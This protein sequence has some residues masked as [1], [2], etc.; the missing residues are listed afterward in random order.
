MAIDEDVDHDSLTG[1]KSGVS[2]DRLP[3]PVGQAGFEASLEKLR[4]LLGSIKITL[5][6]VSISWIVETAGLMPRSW[7]KC[8]PI[9]AAS[10]EA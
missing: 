4:R 10:V 6:P 2:E 7:C 8:G 1:I 3:G 9:V 5:S